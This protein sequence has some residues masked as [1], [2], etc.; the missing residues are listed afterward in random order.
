MNN[1]VGQIGYST[2]FAS[3]ITTK[4]GWFFSDIL[5]NTPAGIAAYWHKPGAVL[6]QRPI[7]RY[8][9]QNNISTTINARICKPYTL[10]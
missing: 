3:L 8:A 7:Q 5:P 10:K 9:N 6:E 4:S 1:G 2:N